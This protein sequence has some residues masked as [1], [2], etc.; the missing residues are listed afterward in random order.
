MT[1]ASASDEDVQ[2][3]L[4]EAYESKNLRGKALLKARRLIEL[5]RTSGKR[6]RG[7]TRKHDAKDVSSDTLLRTYRK[8]TQRQ[9]LV[10]QKAKVGE[11]RLLF[12]VSGLKQLCQDENFV[13]LLRAEG[14]ET[15]P[16]FLAARIYGGGEA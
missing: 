3:A 2:R 1:I 11:A 13:T 15:L 12:V 10:I 8:E 7:V 5:R 16:K 9:R 4:T 14:L 6:A